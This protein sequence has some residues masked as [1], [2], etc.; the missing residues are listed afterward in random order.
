[1]KFTRIKTTKQERRFIRNK[2][3]LE[4][5]LIS[6]I[7][8]SPINDE[9]YRPI[10][11][12]DPE[13][14]KLQ[15]DIKQRGLLESVVLSLD[16][17]IISGHRRYHAC[18]V[19]G[20][21]IIPCRRENIC[22]DDP[23]FIKRLRAYNLHRVK[24]TDESMRESIIDVNEEDAYE[25]LCIEREDRAA[26][27]V[28]TMVIEEWKDRPK[29]SP[30]K[31]PFLNAILEAIEARKDFLPI[32]DCVFQSNWPAFPLITGHSIRW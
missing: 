18:V 25:W 3:E 12:D 11:S 5:V 15:K 27:N 2:R 1:M 9:L 21:K 17:F 31:I 13:N 24:S 26:V 23:E 29:I 10:C 14:R 22:S 19:V 8:I 7:K 28:E 16:N 4:H 20:L 32:S 6:D 30:A